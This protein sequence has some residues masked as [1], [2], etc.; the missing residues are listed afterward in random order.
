VR[1]AGA[2]AEHFEGAEGRSPDV[3]EARVVDLARNKD[4]PLDPGI[5][6]DVERRRQVV[7]KRVPDRPA[8]DRDG[9][10]RELVADDELLDHRLAVCRRADLGERRA[11]LAA[12]AD[13][14]GALRPGP[15]GRLEHHRIAH[16]VDEGPGFGVARD[17]LVAGAGDAGTLQHGLHPR[18]VAEV[19]CHLR[20]HAF[21]AESV[22][23]LA[24][25]HLQ[26]FESTDE[27]L[28]RSDLPRQAAH[29]VGDLLRIEAVGDA[30]VRGELRLQAGWQPL[31]R[32]LADEA[33]GDARQVGDRFDEA[34][35][36]IEKE[37][38]DEDDR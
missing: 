38:G 10:E 34:Q 1:Q 19:L 31:G 27:A 35:C 4:A 6:D 8:A 20:T 11:Q 5:V 28:R 21:D 25:R 14:K 36:R 9:V 22:A 37:R 24:E 13:A 3:V 32:I 33:G 2:H 18:L 30:V 26:L 23:H 12:I 29:G 16:A 17:A 7:R 15:G